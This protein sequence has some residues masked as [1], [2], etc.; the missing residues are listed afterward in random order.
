[1]CP[2]TFSVCSSFLAM[3]PFPPRLPSAHDR[4]QA[5]SCVSQGTLFQG[6]GVL[7]RPAAASTRDRAADGEDPGG[8]VGATAWRGEAGSTY[9]R[10][11]VGGTTESVSILYL[12]RGSIY[13]CGL[14]SCRTPWANA[15]DTYFSRG[16][17]KQ[18]L[19]AIEKAAFF[20]TLDDTEQRYD[21]NNPVT[22]L[23]SYAKSL[24][25]GKCYDRW[26]TRSLRITF[27]FSPEQTDRVVSFAGGLI[28]PLTWLFS[29]MAPWGWT[30]SIPGRTLR[31]SVTYGRCVHSYISRSL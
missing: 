7:W 10:R 16:K 19:D 31:S 18:S 27:L 3:G 28:N 29:K 6:V 30:Q 2:L 13:W 8:S 5:H 23:D 26:G 24:L 9:C 20:V 4:N 21:S 25:H 14:I 15:R 22:S 12:R 1:M 17:N 11:Q